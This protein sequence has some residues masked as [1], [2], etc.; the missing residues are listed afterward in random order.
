[1][2]IALT[3][4]QAAAP[5]AADT[6]RVREVHTAPTADA[7]LDSLTWGKPQVILPA[8][9]GRTSVWLLRAADT[10]FIVAR[11][12]DRSASWADAL[13]ICFDVS[14]DRAGAPA[15]DDFQFLLRRALDSSVVYRGR[16][17][18]WEPP[19]DDPDWR[20]GPSHAG[21]GWEVSAM[22]DPS[23]WSV[24]LRLD[25][26]WL[27]GEGGRLPAVA[28]LVHDDDPNGW[29]GWPRRGMDG[30]VTALE[31]TPGWW[32]PLK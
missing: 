17:G 3:V 23:G 19:L 7:R 25:P 26:A 20:L 31:R 9:Q 32:V 10:V 6:L 1:L 12:P 21:G 4:V 2:L 18:R 28:F 8:R 5:A 27:A 24:E 16:G 11:I 15:H 13:A 22:E 30:S 29:Y 14:G